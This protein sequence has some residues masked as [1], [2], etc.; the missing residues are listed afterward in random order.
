MNPRFLQADSEDWSDWADVQA[1]LSLRWPQR[2][3]SLVLSCCSTFQQRQPSELTIARLNYIFSSVD[4]SKIC[5]YFNAPPIL[6]LMIVSVL[7]SPLID[8]V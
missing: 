3:F 7:L 2:S 5:F 4:L 6:A 1:D 8:K